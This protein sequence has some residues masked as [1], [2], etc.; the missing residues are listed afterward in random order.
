M[1]TLYKLT[2]PSGKSYIGISSK[3]TEQRW[4]KH[5]EHA[6]GK[7]DNGALYA[8]LR[9]YGCDNF[10]VETLVICDKWD[11]LC[12]LEVKAIVA[13]GTKSPNGYNLTDGGEGVQG[14]R[15]A[16]A[17]AAISAA[18]KK[19]FENPEQRALMAE[20]AA[21]SA[22]KSRERHAANRIDGLAPWEVKEKASRVRNGSPEHRAL[23]SART[24]EAMSTPEVKAKLGVAARARA[25]DP[26]Y[27]RKMAASKIGKKLPPHT[28]EAKKKQSDS[29]KAAWARRKALKEQN[30]NKETSTH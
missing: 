12:D 1:G 27:L 22:A 2:S 13:Y 3:T 25:A 28:E 10:K 23:I 29:M 17:K 26:E 18:Q 30:G 24:K 5:K 9:K 7:R 14:P 15:D 19:R 16:K 11:Y 8:A 6:L 21:K 4:A 20:Y